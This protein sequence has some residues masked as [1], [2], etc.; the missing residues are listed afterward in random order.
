MTKEELKTDEPKHII[1]L[2]IKD[3][4][5]KEAEEWLSITD[6]HLNDERTHFLSESEYAEQAYLAGAEPREK[7]IAELEEK[8]TEKVTLESLDVVSGKITE[9][10]EAKANLEYLLEGRDNEIAD[11]EKKNKVLAQNLEDTEIINAGLKKKLKEELKTIA[12]KDLSFV[13]RFDALEKE[14]AELKDDNKV[15]ADNYSKM[16]QKFYDNLTK[17]KEIIKKLMEHLSRYVWIGDNKTKPAM[18][19]DITEAEQFLNSEV[20]K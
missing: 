6:N 4:L 1:E 2:V 17:A 20:K 10:E 13:A 11:L 15:M 9:L 12:D 18:E 19:K 3:K 5:K 16:E 14:N 7:R 8:L